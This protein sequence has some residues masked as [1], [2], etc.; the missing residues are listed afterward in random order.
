MMLQVPQK[1]P[2][3]C[4]GLEH[5]R[6]DPMCQKCPHFDGCLEHMGSRADKVPLNRVRFN[7]LPEKF[8]QHIYDLDDPELPFLQRIYSDCYLTVFHRNPTDNVGQYKEKVA[9]NARAASC[10]LRMFI[11]A[12]M[13]AHEVHEQEVIEHTEK[14]RSAP[15]R[16]KLLTGDFAVKRAQTYQQLC[17]D[18]YGSFTLKSLDVLT[19]EDRHPADSVMER[20]ETTAALWLV[21]FK[22]F[23][24]VQRD[25]TFLAFYEAKEFELD[26]EWLALEE[27]YERLIFNPHTKKQTGT[28]AVRRHRFN[29]GMVL[30]HYKKHPA[31]AR[32]AWLARQEVLPATLSTVLSRFAYR[33]EDFLYPRDPITDIMGF[34]LELGMVI[35]HNQCWKYLEGEPSLFGPRRNETLVRRS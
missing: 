8:R 25:P 4:Y 34:W 6:S 35:R 17:R 30:G 31:L 23:K 22:I 10:S 15:F 7:I 1:A 20:N 19:D 2:L 33:P 5:N 27:N 14:M 3:P 18:R 26:P 24:G 13:V 29:V 11:L 32:E 28:E 9:A 16:V 21:R 12:N